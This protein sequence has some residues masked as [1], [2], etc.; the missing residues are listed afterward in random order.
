ME[1]ASGGKV[2]VSSC[3][4]SGTSTIDYRAGSG[5]GS[6]AG[7]MHGGGACV[8]GYALQDWLDQQATVMEEL[9]EARE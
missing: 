2:S 5:S 6:R 7:A 3:R 9:H 4:P 1:N 8:D